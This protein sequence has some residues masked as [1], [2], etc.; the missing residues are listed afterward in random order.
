MS[1]LAVLLRKI[2]RA[3]PQPFGFGAGPRRPSPTM[4]LIGL[5]SERWPRHV[6]E[7]ANAGADAF[8]LTGKP[9]ESDLASAA[10]A[11]GERPCGLLLPHPT[12]GDV[13]R[14]KKVGLD[15]LV[16]PLEAPAAL[17]G[18]EDLGLLLTLTD[19]L[20][21]VELRT[22]DGLAV[23]GIY[24]EQQAGALTIRQQINLQRISGLTRKPLMLHI[25]PTADQDDLLSLRD[26]GAP[27]VALD[28]KERDALDA[29]RR[30]RTVIDTLPPR[31]KRRREERPEVVLPRTTAREMAEE[32]EGEGAAAL[33][34]AETP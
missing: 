2:T 3:E 7:A 28:L 9:S 23:D 22:I 25:R 21:D 10:A 17:L 31:R 33:P 32:D 29:L 19:D 4:L 8:L 14:A 12:P 20:T 27:L 18:D 26:A 11:A 30:L 24:L 16:T 34:G 15:F 1:K 5:A 6:D 13:E